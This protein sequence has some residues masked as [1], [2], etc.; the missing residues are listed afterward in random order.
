MYLYDKRIILI[1]NFNEKLSRKSNSASEKKN[2]CFLTGKK[3]P[4]YQHLQKDSLEKV[5]P[6]FSNFRI[7]I[8]S[9]P[10]KLLLS[11]KLKYLFKKNLMLLI[12][13]LSKTYSL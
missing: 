7:K 10:S 5:F 1:K 8:K 3:L 12:F 2:W 6:F 11:N 4:N 13:K 9:R